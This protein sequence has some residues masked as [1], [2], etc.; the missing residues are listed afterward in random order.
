MKETPPITLDPV[1]DIPPQD[2]SE[3]R[4]EPSRLKNLGIITLKQLDIPLDEIDKAQRDVVTS[5]LYR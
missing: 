1:L 3:Q 4:R 2:T 5:Y